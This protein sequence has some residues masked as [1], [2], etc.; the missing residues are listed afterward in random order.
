MARGRSSTRETYT[1]TYLNKEMDNFAQQAG[2]LEGIRNLETPLRLSFTP[3]AS[4]ASDRYPLDEG[5][6]GSSM[7]YRGGMDLQYGINES[8]T[9][10][11]TLIPDF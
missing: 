6:I 2:L 5:G 7:S 3:Y 8:F 11:M 10:D 1:W 4:V 9:L